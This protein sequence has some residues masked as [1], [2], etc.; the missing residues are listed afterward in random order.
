MEPT[1][2]VDAIFT[3]AFEPE[4]LEQSLVWKKKESSTKWIISIGKSDDSL[5]QNYKN[6]DLEYFLSL[7]K[8][9]ISN[10]VFIVDSTCKHTYD[11]ARL[12]DKLAS[13]HRFQNILIISAPYHM[14]RV[15]YIFD[16]MKSEKNNSY[17]YYT[18]PDWGLYSNHIN[19]EYFYNS[20]HTRIW[21]EP[22]SMRPFIYSWQFVIKEWVKYFIY[23]LYFR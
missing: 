21:K 23:K 5:T 16:K 12:L 7:H 2:S 20:H 6:H 13:T 4:R 22:L 19:K 11:E 1:E 10:D 9:T 14:R 17:Y 8:L 18:C 15:K 3:L